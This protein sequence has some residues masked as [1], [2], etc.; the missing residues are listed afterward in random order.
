VRRGKDVTVGNWTE[1]SIKADPI[2]MSFYSGE[3]PKKE[4]FEDLL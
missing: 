3:S 2:V 4:S 1:A